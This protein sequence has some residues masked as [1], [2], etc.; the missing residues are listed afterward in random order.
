MNRIV[1]S[2]LFASICCHFVYADKPSDKM[3]QRVYDTF[4]DY[5]LNA[6]AVQSK[7][8]V[9]IGRGVISFS[10]KGK[11]YATPTW[12]IKAK[13]DAL[14]Q[15]D[16]HAKDIASSA[17]GVREK[18]LMRLRDDDKYR[19]R[20][21]PLYHHPERVYDSPKE[22]K[23]GD[24]Y[25]HRLVFMEPFKQPTSNGTSLSS[26]QFTRSPFDRFVLPKYKVENA[27]QVGKQLKVDL[28]SSYSDRRIRHSLTFDAKY[29]YM[30]TEYI[31]AIA[32]AESENRFVTYTHNVSKWKKLSTGYV[33]TS[34]ESS[35][36]KLD[37]SWHVKFDF[38]WRVGA[39][40]PKGIIHAGLPDW[41]EPTRKLFD[42][43]WQRDG[44]FSRSTASLFEE[45]K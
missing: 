45:E 1:F 10:A 31:L 37:P 17:G 19:F 7:K 11:D 28:L 4:A 41:R 40:V 38:D 8:Y 44:N 22:I 12:F 24:H 23:E 15:L 20:D 9:C 6:Q 43:E 13:V 27:T 14:H 33:P 29:E 32:N 25:D 26:S 34:F 35:K 30:L 5:D 36:P 21:S 42:V 16:A 39:S 3:I 18:W 2:L